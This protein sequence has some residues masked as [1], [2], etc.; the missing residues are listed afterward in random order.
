MIDLRKNHGSLTPTSSRKGESYVSKQTTAT[1]N[2]NKV[3]DNVIQSY[4]T[5]RRHKET[6]A[7]NNLFT[8]YLVT[9]E[10]YSIKDGKIASFD[11]KFYDPVKKKSFWRVVYACR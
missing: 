6:M 2:R 11:K 8:T 10:R 4:P 7:S 9:G 1:P 5:G 3:E